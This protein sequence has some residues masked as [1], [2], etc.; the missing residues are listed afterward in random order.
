MLSNA[1]A[2]SPFF[3]AVP[4]GRQSSSLYYVIALVCFCVKFLYHS[5]AA[6]ARPPLHAPCRAVPS[7]LSLVSSAAA[8]L[9][10][11]AE[12]K[13]KSKN[14]VFLLIGLAGAV[15]WEKGKSEC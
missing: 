10:S 11:T 12:K 13:K 5:P 14:E 6:S 8:V 15:L 7:L 3:G 4:R 1:R 9:I 2:R